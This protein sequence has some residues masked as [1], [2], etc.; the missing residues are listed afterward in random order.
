MFSRRSFGNGKVRNCLFDDTPGWSSAFSRDAFCSKGFPLLLLIKGGTNWFREEKESFEEPNAV[1]TPPWCSV[2]GV[3][4]LWPQLLEKNSHQ[5]L[6]GYHGSFGPKYLLHRMNYCTDSLSLSKISLCLWRKL[7][8]PPQSQSLCK[9]LAM[10]E[11]PC[12]PRD[13]L[14][15]NQD[16]RAG[17]HTGDAKG[18]VRHFS[19]LFHGPG[20]SSPGCCSKESVKMGSGLSAWTQEMHMA[21]L[22]TWSFVPVPDIC[23]CYSYMYFFKI[24]S[25]PYCKRTRPKKAGGLACGHKEKRESFI[26]FSSVA[27]NLPLQ[28][29]CSVTCQRM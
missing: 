23:I 5:E 29:E 27:R 13:F 10:Q 20:N 18:S 4:V 15:V 21:P 2:S 28:S 6:Q 24:W 8:H 7:P 25:V 14:L 19:H 17:R 26:S 9:Q 22:C 12:W 11:F 16:C 1:E 3:A